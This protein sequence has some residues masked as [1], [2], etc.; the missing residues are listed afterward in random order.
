MRGIATSAAKRPKFP[1]RHF[2]RAEAQCL[3]S[4]R[5]S[6]FMAVSLQPDGE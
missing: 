3:I 4:G 1:D 2:S 6:M 5:F